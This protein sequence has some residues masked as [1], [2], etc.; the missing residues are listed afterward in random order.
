MRRH[1]LTAR[2]ETAPVLQ[3][4]SSLTSQK[5]EVETKQQLLD[6]F[7]KHFVISDEDLTTLTSPTEPVNDRFFEVVNRLKGIHKDCQV[8]L[9]SSSQTLGLEVMEQSSRNLNSGYQKL[10]RWVQREFK[11]LHLENPQISTPI[12]QA[13]RVLAERPS[14]FQS[15]LD[16]FSEVR[17]NILLDSFHTALT[18]TS[19][20]S[21]QQST[22][23]PIELFAHDPLRYIGDMLAWTHSATVSEQEALEVLF[24]SEGQEIAKGI[25]TGRDNEPWALAE[26]EEDVVFDGRKALEQLVNRDVAGVAR[27]IRQRIE[28]VIQSHDESILAYKIANLIKFYRITFSKLIGSDST[29]SD[30]LTFLEES[31]LHQFRTTQRDHITSIRSEP[32]HPPADL[33]VPDF[34]T[35]AFDLLTALLQTHST[36]LIPSTS[37][38]DSAAAFQPILT[39]ALDPYLATC[40]DLARTLPAPDDST[41]FALNCLLATKATLAPFPFTH[42]RLADLDDTIDEHALTLVAHQ[43]AFFLRASGLQPLRAALAPLSHAQEDLL[44]VP[45]LAPF[46][47]QALAEA[48]RTLDDFLP[49]A[50]LDAMENLGRLQSR[51]LVGDLTEQAAGLFCDDFEGVV[52]KMEAVDE[53]L[54]LSRA[55]GDEGD[56][57]EG[58]ERE[59]ED[60]DEGEDDHDHGDERVGGAGKVRVRLRALFPRTSAEIRL[61]LS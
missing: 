46:H 18:G 24:I 6:A 49:T 21:E 38:S 23:K 12:R 34:L 10:Y 52:E 54:L 2:K 29:L 28:Q 37:P 57:E 60:E 44:S 1:V 26:G 35:D 19:S 32:T 20:N 17:E 31:A 53:V 27:V 42:D 48:S 50:L 13:L 9:G 47:P 11:T 39:E 43:H 8:L 5:T 56:G 4:A 59:D 40:S 41:I 33:S 55:E 61:L 30:T 58:G 15:C 22:T 51:S 16:S 45:H 36:S 7:N 3:E 25:Q 14:L